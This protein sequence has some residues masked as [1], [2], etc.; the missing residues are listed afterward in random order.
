MIAIEHFQCTCGNDEFHFA[1]RGD[2]P[3]I[4]CTE[5]GLTWEDLGNPST[6]KENEKKVFQVKEELNGSGNEHTELS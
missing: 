6:K 1:K 2:D 5:C 3:I 4:I